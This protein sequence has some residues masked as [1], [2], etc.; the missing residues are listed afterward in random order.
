MLYRVVRL[1]RPN[2]NEIETELFPCNSLDPTPSHTTREN[3]LEYIRGLLTPV[4]LPGFAE[5]RRVNLAHVDMV[6]ERGRFVSW[7]I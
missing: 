3:C 6:D 5:K 7:E 2:G 1:K 4:P